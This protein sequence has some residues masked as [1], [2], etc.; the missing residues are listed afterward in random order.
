[1]LKLAAP[2]AFAGVIPR[3]APTKSIGRVV[4]N[5][6]LIPGFEFFDVP[7]SDRKL[8]N[9]AL[10]LMEVKRLIFFIDATDKHRLPSA[11]IEL[12][13]AMEIVDSD[14]LVFLTKIDLH[15]SNIHESIR[16][17]GLERNAL[18]AVTIEPASILHIAPV[19]EIIVKYSK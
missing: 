12:E 15:V 11:L 7:G 9:T 2:N 6:P 13:Y 1:M 5:S 14:A 4:I 18:A 16:E 19:A 10:Q 8:L 17:L 3:P